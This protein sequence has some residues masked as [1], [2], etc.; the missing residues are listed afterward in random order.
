MEMKRKIKNKNKASLLSLTLI[1]AVSPVVSIPGTVQLPT[2]L[3]SREVHEKVWCTIQM[4]R[5]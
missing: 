3:Q 2:A 4:S 1:L 5:L